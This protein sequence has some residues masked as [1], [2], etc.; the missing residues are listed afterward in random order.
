MQNETSPLF[1]SLLYGGDYNPEQWPEAV[2][3]EDLRLMQAAA[4]NIATLPVFGWVSL[5]P[6]EDTWTFE[7]LDRV[8]EKLS[9]QGVGLCLAT[10][11]ASVPAWVAQKYPEV[12]MVSRDGVP[13]HHGARH[14]F[15]PTSPHFRRLSRQLAGRIAE[16]YASHPALRLWHIGNEYGGNSTQGRCYCDLCAA[17]FR[18]WLKTRYGTLEELN[19]RWYTRFWGHTFTDWAQI[20]PPFSTGENLMQAL[21]LDYDR[22]QSESL[23]D[24]FK[25]ERDAVRAF[26]PAI[27]I[28]TNFMGTFKPLDYYAWAKEVDV[29]SWDSY[30]ARGATAAEIAF[31]HSL[32]RGLKEGQPWLLMEQTPSQQNWQPYNSLKQP[33]ILRLWSLQAVAHGSDAVMYFQW[34][35]SQSGTEKYHGAVVEPSGRDDTRVFR[36]VAGLGQELAALGTQTLGGRVSA[37]VALLFD[38]ENWWDVDYSVGPSIDL[39]YVPQLQA[40]YTAL[41]TLGVPTDVVSPDADLSGYRMVIAPLLALM[42]P[43]VAAGLEAWTE[44]GG[45]FV[46]TCFSGMV[47]ENDHLSPD[48][49]P[50]PL[51]SLLGLR[52]EETDALAP[53]E[54][55]EIVFTAP[56]GTLQGG[57]PARILCDRVHLEG[58]EAVATFGK[59]FYAGEPALTVHSFGAG[60][61]Y[62]LATFAEPDAL[63]EVVRELCVRHE[64]PSPLPDTPPPGVEVVPRV[65]P[66]GQT[67][68]YV[69]NHAAEARHVSL[70]AGDHTDLL[71]QSVLSGTAELAPYAVLI[72]RAVAG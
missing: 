33:G 35:R 52:V 1:S 61:A 70:P 22:F 36:E 68:L 30:P 38:W 60:S 12:L 59:N 37:P 23:L 64:I 18:T 34:R 72:L 2:W 9:A 5:Q 26:S 19:S 40:W 46:A 57:V 15:C 3:D 50:G 10:A 39:K 53:T 71:T 21:S 13:R 11:T 4:V 41:H 51:R 32:M 7:W 24:C 66:G 28:T 14:T 54:S 48:G 42:K 56:F 49:P 63:T 44:A 67:L 47:D 45:T 43:G 69:L 16:R 8:I 29:V 58:A 31:Q 20:E 25:A 62:Y 65:S 55:N 17:A 6:D 27:P